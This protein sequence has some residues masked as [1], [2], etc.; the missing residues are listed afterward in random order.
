[1]A[2]GVCTADMLDALLRTSLPPLPAQAVSS[3]SALHARLGS[4]NADMCDTCKL[5]VLEASAIL[6]NV[7]RAWL[8]GARC[9]LSTKAT[10]AL[11]AGPLLCRRHRSR[12]WS[13][14]SRCA[15]R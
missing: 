14:P 5:A 12:S 9:S 4:S 11:M 3:L 7:V 8:A 2:S 1:M 15:R 6:G 13:T 10:E